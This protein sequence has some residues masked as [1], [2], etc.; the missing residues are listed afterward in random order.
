MEIVRCDVCGAEIRRYED[1]ELHEWK[2]IRSFHGGAGVGDP[3]VCPKCIKSL[4]NKIK[5]CRKS[6][7][8]VDDQKT[9]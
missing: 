5:K 8:Y 2:C 1:G 7:G 6:Y 4:L 9:I 3:A